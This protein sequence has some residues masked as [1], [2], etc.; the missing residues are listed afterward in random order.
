MNELDVIY[1]A[2]AA[3]GFS[4]ETL[5]KIDDL[6]NNILQNSLFKAHAE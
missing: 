5:Q 3:S 4:K 1:A 6:T 2:I